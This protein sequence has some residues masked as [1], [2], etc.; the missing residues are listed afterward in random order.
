MSALTI[1]PRLDCALVAAG[2][3]TDRGL[4]IDV[5]AP[6]ADSVVDEQRRPLNLALVLDRS[7]SMSGWPVD[8]VRRAALGVA[9]RLDARDLLS[10]VAFD[11]RVD[12][13]ADAVR[14]DARGRDRVREALA[15]L[16]S[17]GSTDLGAGWFEGARCV[18]AAIAREHHAT[19]H[20][21]LLSDGQANQGMCDPEELRGH[22][23][24]LAR[25]GVTSSAVGVGLG[26]SPV[27]LDAIAQGGEGRLNHC[28]D[29]DDIEDVILGEVLEEREVVAADVVL[30]LR[31]ERGTEFTILSEF[32]QEEDGGCIRL[33]LGSLRAGG[34]RSPAMLV[35]VPELAL[36]DSEQLRM[37]VSWTDV[38]TNSRHH[39]EA[40]P[41]VMRAANQEE[42]DA[43]PRDDAVVQRILQLWEASLVYRGARFNSESLFDAAGAVYEESEHRLELF[44]RGVP[45]YEER[46]R[47]FARQRD[48]VAHASMEP[49]ALRESIDM[50][51]KQMRSER[52]LRRRDRSGW[53]DRV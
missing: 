45:G 31:T 49:M 13:L 38:A 5:A 4:L 6:A 14:M 18:S 25:R 36:G 32:P 39:I 19:G 10:V 41:V 17:R 27:Q 40:A 30:E 22:A 28:A 11:D 53:E 8:A 29:G 16:D 12:L 44:A 50:S 23:S 7:G 43:A 37:A 35:C 52:D 3:V 24:E 21:V 42:V 9:E 47:R 20:V 33:R 34:A 26:Y 46:M 51:R 48:V 15:R 2:E 1:T